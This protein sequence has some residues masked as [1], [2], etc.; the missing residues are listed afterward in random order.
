[1]YKLK[2]GYSKTAKAITQAVLHPAL[3]KT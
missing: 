1:M 3:N 2:A